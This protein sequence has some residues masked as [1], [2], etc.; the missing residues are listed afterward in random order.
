MNNVTKILAQSGVI[1]LQCAATSAASYVTDT[2]IDMYAQPKDMSKLSEEEQEKELKKFCKNIKF[3]KFAAT[4]TESALLG[5][6]SAGCCIGIEK[7][8][9]KSTTSSESSRETASNQSCLIGC[10]Y[11]I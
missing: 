8:A 7:A 5:A 3:A 10:N 2:L 11:F 6:A 4:V 1:L 9:A